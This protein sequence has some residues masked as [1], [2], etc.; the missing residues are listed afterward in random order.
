MNKINYLPA[1][2]SRLCPSHVLN[3]I[4]EPT[5]SQGITSNHLFGIW[6]PRECAVRDEEK[7]DTG[8]GSFYKQ[9]KRG[10]T[11]LTCITASPEHHI[12]LNIVT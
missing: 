3:F 1:S 2:T 12:Y 11:G 4:S 8:R 10:N 5:H 9:G 6:N 7:W